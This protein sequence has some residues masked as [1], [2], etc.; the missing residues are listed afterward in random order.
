MAE[1]DPKLALLLIY[2]W[3]LDSESSKPAESPKG[4]A[5]GELHGCPGSTGD[6][7]KTS[8]G[9]QHEGQRENKRYHTPGDLEGV[10]GYCPGVG[11]MLA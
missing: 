8:R 10:G 5:R 7:L 3:C 4:D 6:S 11:I 2:L 1:I 9:G